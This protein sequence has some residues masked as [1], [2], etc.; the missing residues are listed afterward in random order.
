VNRAAFRNWLAIFCLFSAGLSRE[1]AAQDQSHRPSKFVAQSQA[2]VSAEQPSWS[3]AVSGDS[4]NC[5]DVV[6]P[7]IAAGAAK[8]GAAFYWHL[9]DFRAIYNFDED[10]QHQPKYLANPP[11]IASYEELAWKD[12]IESQLLPFGTLPV[13]LGIGNHETIP[14]KTRGEYLLQFADWLETPRLRGQRLNDDPHDFQLKTYYHWIQGGV[15]FINLDNATPEQFDRAQ[16]T[17][18]EKTLKAASLNPQVYSLII[19]MHEALPESISKDHSMNQSPSGIESGRRV[20]EDLLKIQNEPQKHVY[21]LASHSH[22]FMDGIFNTDYWRTHGGVLP[23]WI[24]GTAGAQR[25]AL[26]K[27]S[28]SARAAQTDVYGF[29]LGT[30]KSDGEIKFAFQRLDQSDIPAPVADRY[31]RNF[32]HWCFADNS[33]AH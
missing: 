12:F 20:Y 22:Y 16:I 27:E 32:I 9:G 30:V 21:V 26:P 13:Y 15:D 10:I 17:W 19:G 2:A 18:F 3:F 24:I 1:G 7:A 4:R 29:L 14:P 28:A 8:A 11:D 31:A 23:G 25:Y 5:G 33:I 6:M